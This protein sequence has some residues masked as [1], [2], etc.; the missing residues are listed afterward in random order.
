[1]E[2]I[3]NESCGIPSVHEMKGN[4]MIHCRFTV[5]TSNGTKG[6]A[7]NRLQIHLYVALFF[8]ICS[9]LITSGTASLISPADHEI[10][11]DQ[12]THVKNNR[13]HELPHSLCGIDE[14]MMAPTRI[15]PETRQSDKASDSKS[16]S[17]ME[18]KSGDAGLSNLGP[19]SW[20]QPADDL[21]RMLF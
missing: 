8:L 2:W 11:G 10:L 7:V 17:S 5:F 20:N 12:V 19:L 3:G 4:E 1:M 14:C 6:V 16:R 18:M 15:I 13:I 21:R 9:G